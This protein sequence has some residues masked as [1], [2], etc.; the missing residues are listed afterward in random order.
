MNLKTKLALWYIRRKL[1]A[2]IKKGSKMKPLPKWMA[3]LSNLGAVGSIL[4]TLG[5]MLP[6]KY[7]VAIAGAAAII[8][9]VAHSLPGTGGK[10]Q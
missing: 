2:I 9:S 4:A 8:N 6:P 3:W 5:N 1:V 10:L 7:G